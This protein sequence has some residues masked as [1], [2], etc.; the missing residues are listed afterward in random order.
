MDNNN[1]EPNTNQGTQNEPSNQGTQTEPS[2]PD[3]VIQNQALQD[4]LRQ[5]AETMQALKDELAQ[6]KLANAKMVEQLDVSRNQPS[7][8]DIINSNFNRYLK[9]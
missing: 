2:N 1:Q 8:D 3:L 4:L 9:K 6:V 7:V 5:N